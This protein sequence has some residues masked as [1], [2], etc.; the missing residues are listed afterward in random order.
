MALRTPDVPDRLAELLGTVRLDERREN[1]LWLRLLG[2]SYPAPVESFRGP[3]MRG[4]IAEAMSRNGYDKSRIEREMSDFLLSDDSF[5]WI[6]SDD[7]QI[8]WVL[9]YFF[10]TSNYFIQIQPPRLK[11]R[12][13]LIS[14]ID[15]WPVPLTQKAGT[16]RSLHQAWNEH[17]KR[18]TYLSWFQKDD[19]SAKIALAW[20]FF[21]KNS[22][23]TYGVAPFKTKD[24]IS[25]FFDKMQ[26]SDAEKQHYIDK[27]KALWRQRSYRAR[28]QGKKQYNFVLS[29]HAVAQLDQLSKQRRMSRAELLEALI[30]SE[31]EKSTAASRGL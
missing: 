21:L 4:A 11:G 12:A 13:L 5:E 8:D 2:Q 19:A 7:R 10:S 6:K 20:D 14:T 28:Q 3:T 1:W 17:L 31:F 23:G 18:D 24:D 15:T 26:W 9:K 22:Y 25:S 27:I 16:V 30:L 29:I